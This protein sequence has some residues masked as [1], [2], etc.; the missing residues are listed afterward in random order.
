MVVSNSGIKDKSKLLKFLY[1]NPEKLAQKLSGFM[2]NNDGELL[3]MVKLK[4]K[5][6]GYY[7]SVNHK[8]LIRVSRDD[9]FYLLPLRDDVD[10]N[11]RYIYTHYNWMVGCVLLVDKDDIAPIGYN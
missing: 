2:Q 1:K 11:K 9:E 6:Q 7:Y 8:R 5:G 4:G 3:P 10:K